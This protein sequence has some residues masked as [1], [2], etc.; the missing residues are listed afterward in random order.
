MNRNLGDQSTESNERR[1]V[2]PVLMI[3]TGGCLGA[4][5]LYA[6]LFAP[7]HLPRFKLYI[8]ALACAL[9]S[10][11]FASLFLGSLG[12]S[13]TLAQLGPW[14]MTV[15][16]TGGFAM[17]VFVLVWFL[18]PFSPTEMDENAVIQH[19]RGGSGD[20][21]QEAYSRGRSIHQHAEDIDGRVIQRAG[22]GDPSGSGHENIDAMMGE[23]DDR[24]RTLRARS[25]RARS[26]A[27][28]SR[29]KPEQRSSSFEK[30]PKRQQIRYAQERLKELGYYHDSI[31]GI[32]GKNTRAALKQFQR[33]V[34]V[35][36]TGH[37]DRETAILL[38]L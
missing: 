18:R 22:S 29:L 25:Q 13:Q 16:A 38:G 30:L 24:L 17:A 2:K 9:F 37:L 5:V 7:D 6:F 35:R 32:A 28:E 31:D 15:N 20:T 8:L 23:L 19:V 4:F 36:E 14:K 10:G 33:D 26:H 21:V 34:G 3:L 12:V 11:L 1:R 27:M